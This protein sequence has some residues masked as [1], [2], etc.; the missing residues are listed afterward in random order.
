M[1]FNSFITLAVAAAQSTS[2]LGINCHGE[3]GIAILSGARLSLFQSIFD[4]LFDKRIYDNGDD[5]GC[6]EVDS[7]NFIG[8]SKETFC[9]YIQN[10][11][12][13]VSG[14]T[15]KSL[16]TELVEYGCALCGSVPLLYAKGDDDVNHGELSINLVES[17]PDNCELNKPCS[18]T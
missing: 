17:L 5:V 3:C 9:A 10:S 2:A 16:Y 7:V 8:S 11:A 14:A 6:I 15:L 12:D 1:H 18:A 4:N 13:S